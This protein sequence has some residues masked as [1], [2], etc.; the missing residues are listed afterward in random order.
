MPGD[1]DPL[2]VRART[3]LLDALDA[4]EPHLDAL[5]L[6]GAQAVYLHTSETEL[7]VAEYT[8]DADLA[9]APGELADT[10]AAGEPPPGGGGGT[11]CPGRA[12]GPGG[13]PGGGA[14][15]PFSTARVIDTGSPAGDAITSSVGRM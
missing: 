1:V 11:G 14:P 9:V 6:V 4:L 13:L 15:L 10:P 12:G 8:T 3:A 7:A 5:V 2:Y